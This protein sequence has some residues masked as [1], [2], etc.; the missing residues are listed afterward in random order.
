MLT[1]AFASFFGFHWFCRWLEMQSVH[2]LRLCIR[3]QS[4]CGQNIGLNYLAPFTSFVSHSC[5]SRS[6]QTLFS[7]YFLFV[8]LSLLNSYPLSLISL[9][10]FY[11]PSC[12]C[13]QQ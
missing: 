2:H 9:V 10:S 11:L 8:C 4:N 1:D 7:C 3:K 6:H 13:M 5:S 12:R